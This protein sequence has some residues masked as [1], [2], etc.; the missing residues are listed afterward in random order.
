MNDLQK[1]DDQVRHDEEALAFVPTKD[2]PSFVIQDLLSPVLG[3][4]V[5]LPYAVSFVGVVAAANPSLEKSFPTLLASL[6]FSQGMTSL[7]F[8]RCSQHCVCTN[9][10][11]LQ[12]AYLAAMGRA[13][14]FAGVP[15]DV[16][17]FHIFLAQGLMSLV[18]G[19][20]MWTVAELDGLYYMRFLPYPVSAGF[21]SGIGMMIFDGGLELGC[22]QGLLQLLGDLLTA[23]QSFE[24]T[25]AGIALLLRL[26]L[27]L[28]G[29]G[30]FLGLK[31]LLD[32]YALGR[33]IRLPLGLA[34]ISSVVY[35]FL[36]LHPLSLEELQFWGLFISELRP[37]PWVVEWELLGSGFGSFHARAFFSQPCISVLVSYAALSTLA[38]TFYTVGFQDMAKDPE[39]ELAKEIRLLGKT[40]IALAP[41]AGVPVSHAIKV[42][43]VMRDA[44][45]KT[46]WWV[47]L[48]SVCYMALYFDSTLRSSLSFIP[49]CAFG[50]LVVSL[51][52]EFL[53]TSLVESR[54]RIAATEWRVVVATS[55]ITYLNVLLGILF[56]VVLTTVFFMV[57]YSGMTGVTQKATLSEVRSHV[58]RD[59]EQNQI[60]DTYGR[61]VAVFWCAGY[62]F[63]TAQDIVEELQAS[64]DASP[65]THI[66]ILD[67][68]QVPAVDASGVQALVSFAEKGQRRRPA[69]TLAISGVVRRLQLSL[70]R[71]M[72]ACQVEMKI[73]SHRVEKMLEWAEEWLLSG[74][75]KGRLKSQRSEHQLLASKLAEKLKVPTTKEQDE[76]ELLHFVSEFLLEIASTA[77]AEERAA[78]G[79][80]LAKFG[81]KLK[82]YRNQERLYAEG[83]QAKDLTYVLS[84]S[85]SIVQRISPDE[86]LAYKVPRHHLNEEK[87]DTFAFEEELD[88]RVRKLTHGSVLGAL[89]FGAFC[90]GRA[91]TWHAS[92][93]A[94]PDCMVLRVPFSTLESA[95]ASSQSVGNSVMQWLFKLASIQ[96]L[97]VLQGVRVKPYRRIDQE[98]VFKRAA[99][100]GASPHL[101]PLPYK[102]LAF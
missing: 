62:I 30:I 96:V 90:S 98:G 60:I 69:V 34:V 80:K 42:W 49:K 35:G 97:D 99:S 24:V 13:L 79:E 94:A 56:G 4:A 57:E 2:K 26:C 74:R 71:C 87:G 10:D 38:F 59:D 78:V 65:S 47:L 68:E 32:H 92:A 50:A 70:D 16:L 36:Y 8:W 63:G 40:N 9:V 43:V 11:L 81:S 66:L 75:E 25:H 64:L 33:A 44:G 12:A 86:A 95:M 18:I 28:V 61:Q 73:S 76:K 37:E 48:F 52:F 7:V 5:L 85:V 19:I 29:A 17:L 77:K 23:A 14:T 3:S 102:N 1:I 84:G 20:L 55:V 15:S 72:R 54:E 101:Q 31:E 39:I 27:T 88:I 91:P 41:F 45:G 21:V 67:F 82:T 89:E 51:G 93:C 6:L 58:E 100:S 53:T 46:R 83:Q 22:G